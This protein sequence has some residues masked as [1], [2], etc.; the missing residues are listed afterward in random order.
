GKRVG[1][2]L[3]RRPSADA[4][5]IGVRIAR[6]IVELDEERDI[7]PLSLAEDILKESWPADADPTPPLELLLGAPLADAGEA[8]PEPPPLHDPGI[9]PLVAL[10]VA[11]GFAVEP[12]REALIHAFL[13]SSPGRWRRWSVAVSHF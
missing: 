11:R 13:A 10:A 8:D 12:A 2:A 6:L 4:A 7:D 9:P 1:A 3:A 5:A